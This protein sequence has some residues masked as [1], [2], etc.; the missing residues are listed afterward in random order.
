MS[1]SSN[2]DALFAEIKSALEAKQ[3]VAAGTHG[4][5][6]E[7]MYAG[8]GVYAD[9]A[10]TIFGVSEENGQKYVHLRNPW[11]EVEPSGNGPDDGNFKLE[12]ATFQKL[13][14]SLY[15]S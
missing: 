6:S 4:H 11:G 10:Y 3:S 12:M 8:T 7:S 9:H 13:Y 14:S 15:V 2:G 5:E 1:P